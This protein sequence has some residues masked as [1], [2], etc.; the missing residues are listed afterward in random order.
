MYPS[1]TNYW[2]HLGLYKRRNGPFIWHNEAIPV[3]YTGSEITIIH[4]VC[5]LFSTASMDDFT[6][7]GQNGLHKNLIVCRKF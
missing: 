6:V 3:N 5:T 7:N 2:I 4:G 1:Y